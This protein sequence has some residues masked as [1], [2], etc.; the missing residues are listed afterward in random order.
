MTIKHILFPFDFSR[1]GQQV[2]SVVQAVARRFEATVTLFSVVLPGFDA[3]P[4]GLGVR[5]GE[6]SMEWTRE[7]RSRLDGVL[8]DELADVTVE[9]VAECGDPAEKITEFAHDHDVDL[10]MM[11]THGIGRFRNLLMGSITAKVLHDVKCPVWT[12]AHTESQRL[13]FL[14]K[15]ILCALDGKSDNEALLRWAAGLAAR[16]DATLRL[17][18]VVRFSTDWPPLES[19]RALQDRLRQ[20]SRAQIESIQALAGI[21]APLRVIAGEIVSTVADEASHDVDLVLIGRGS[22]N[23]TLGRLRTHAYGIIQSSPCPVISV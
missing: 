17:V 21:E 16:F 10:I 3:T 6:A 7:L 2:A 11:P 12:A 4:I 15:T 9:R 8:L 14:P 1:Q 20:E 5:P 18:H 13:H 19:E 22:I 23:S